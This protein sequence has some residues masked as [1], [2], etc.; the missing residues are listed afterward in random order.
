MSQKTPSLTFLHCVYVT[1][2]F[3]ID[4][5]I[6]AAYVVL[7]LLYGNKDFT[8]TLDISTRAGQD[9]DCNPS[10]A[11]GILGTILGYDKI[12][13]YWKMGLKEAE[14]I[15]FKYTTI[16]LSD[17]YEIGLKHALQNI[18]KNGGKINGNNISIATQTPDVVKLEQGFPN[19]Y[20]V[21][22]VSLGK[23]DF[24]ELS[25]EFEGTGFILSGSADKKSDKN[26]DYVFDA[27]LFIDGN[28]VETAKLPTNYTTRRLELFWKYDLPKGKHKVEVKVLNPHQD[29]ALNAWEYVV[30][31]DKPSK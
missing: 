25:F 29:Y 30:F 19:I 4:A 16:S 1:R 2:P 21:S 31:S 22:D 6:N 8:K 18:E 17:V 15:D 13:A 14:N 24:K 23:K 11:G 7:G 28:K 9:A 5:K 10:S 27:E 26:A 20:P 3:N 12:P